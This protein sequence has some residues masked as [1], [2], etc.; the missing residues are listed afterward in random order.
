M[1]QYTLVER[2]ASWLSLSRLVAG[3]FCLEPGEEVQQFVRF[4]IDRTGCVRDHQREGVALLQ[5]SELGVMF[6]NFRVECRVE[7]PLVVSERPE[8]PAYR[9]NK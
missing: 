4:E 7:R 3:R 5:T 6:V 2:P 1:T 8:P 9:T